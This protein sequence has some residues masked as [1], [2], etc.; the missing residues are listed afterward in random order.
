MLSL[1]AAGKTRVALED[2][3][4][5]SVGSGSVLFRW[6][7]RA[8]DWVAQTSSTDPLPRG[9]ATLRWP[10]AARRELPDGWSAQLIDTETE[11]RVDLRAESYTFDLEEDGQIEAPEESRFRLRVGPAETLP[12]E[13]AGFEARARARYGSTG[14]P[15][16]KQTT[17]AS[18]CSAAS[19][20]QG[21]SRAGPSCRKRSAGWPAGRIRSAPAGERGGS[22]P[23][24][25]GR[26]LKTL[27]HRSPAPTQACPS[28][29]GFSQSFSHKPSPDQ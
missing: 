18:R 14:R 25:D 8:Q 7:E 9:T 13:M 19:R 2:D 6:D 3:R 29:C 11:T 12:V 5:F 16:R 4:E 15:P 23:A 21:S 24:S 26:A 27:S 1:P 10:E 22:D 17:P 28:E 20:R